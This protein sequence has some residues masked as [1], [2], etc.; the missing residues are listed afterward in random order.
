MRPMGATADGSPTMPMSPGQSMVLDSDARLAV[1]LDGALQDVAVLVVRERR[2]RQHRAAAAGRDRSNH[3]AHVR[4]SAARSSSARSHARCEPDARVGERSS[5][6]LGEIAGTIMR[7]NRPRCS[8]EVDRRVGVLDLGARV[9]QASAAAPSSARYSRVDRAGGRRR[10]TCRCGSRPSDCASHAGSSRR[11]AARAVGL[12]P[13][14]HAEQQVE[15]VGAARDRTEHVDV[16][17]GRAAADVVE[18]AALRHHAEARLQPE[19]AAAVRRD[20]DRAADV[21]AELEAGEAGG[22]RGRGTAR[23]AT[24]GCGRRSTGCW[25]RRRAR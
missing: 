23:R 3:S 24:R 19:H 13:G 14:E 11:H 4:R 5:G 7:L 2:G 1:D 15:V 9:G 8:R 6:R 16:G 18:V 17:V 22:D 21:G 10:T 25:W 12:G 20:A